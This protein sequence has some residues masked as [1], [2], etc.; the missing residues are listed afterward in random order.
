[1]VLIGISGK[2]GSGKDTLA[3][4]IMKNFPELNFQQKSFAYKLKQIV[5]ILSG[6]TID[7]NLTQEGKQRHI[8]EWGMTLG[9]MQQVIGTE[10]IRNHFDQNAWVK[11]LFIDYTP[12]Q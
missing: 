3:Q 12:D 11:A 2:I 1:M 7:E 6:T 8:P 10:C 4:M 9:Q 5:A